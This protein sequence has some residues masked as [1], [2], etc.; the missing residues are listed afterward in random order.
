MRLALF[1]PGGV[2]R[3]GSDRAIPV[4]MALIERLAHRHE[5]H[6]VTLSQ[7]AQP[8]VY[9]ALGATVYDL[10]WP[11]KLRHI[12]IPLIRP[13]IVNLLV[14]SFVG[15]MKLFDLV[16][17]TTQGG[18]LWATET[19]S[20][21]VYKRAFDWSTFDLGYPAAMATIWFVIVLVGVLVLTR[22]LGGR[23]AYEF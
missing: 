8:R 18:P 17:I 15:K 4:F 21:Y 23:E 5:V 11:R 1:L 20:T 10:G 3:A 16:W 2:D 13:T 12:A 9:E 22:G 7:Y 14:L 19:V 6:V